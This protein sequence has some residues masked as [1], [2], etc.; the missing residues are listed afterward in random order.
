M[1]LAEIAE[2]MN[3][4]CKL[5]ELYADASYELTRKSKLSPTEAA[6]AC[7]IYEPYI[8]DILQQADAVITIFKMEK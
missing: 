1:D 4:Y 3:Q 7:K 8:H 2:K 5:W 6:K